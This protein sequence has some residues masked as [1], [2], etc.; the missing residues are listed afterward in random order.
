MV[1]VVLAGLIIVYGTA[2]A[3]QATVNGFVAGTY[4]GLG[5][6]G[7]TLILSVLKLVNFAY[8]D[9]LVAGA[10]LTIMFS[11]MGAPLPLAMVLA[12]LGT[13]VISLATEKFVW[14]PLRKSGASTLQSLLSAIGLGFV[15]RFT[16]QFFGGSQSRTLGADVTSTIILGPIRVGTL[17]AL[18]LL[19]GVAAVMVF[20]LALRFTKM[21]KAIRAFSD[22]QTLAE[23]SGINASKTI[24]VTWIVSGLIAGTAGVLYAAAIGSFNPNFGVALLLSLF[25]AAILGGIGNAYGAL[26]GGIVMGLSQEWSTLLFSARW[27]PAI[28]L[29]LLVAMLLTMPN[30][31]FG[32]SQRQS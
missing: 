8:G 28:G 15:I 25:A 2:K 13:A 24:D 9:L 26:A 7:L 22:N 5:A 27:K 10:Y 1:I 21:G 17:Q 29:A 4:I 19:F 20:G 30:G 32:R 14:R 23:V 6:I 12:V 3:S 11:W 18:S 16:I 31:I